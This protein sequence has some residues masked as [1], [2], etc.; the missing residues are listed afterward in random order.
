MNIQALIE[1]LNNIK[2][3]DL[4]A[5]DYKSILK[6]YTKRIDILIDFVLII[7]TL[8]FCVKY[9]Q[10]RENEIKSATNEIPM[11]KE[12]IAMI[13]AYN[14]ADLELQ[15]FIRG[16]PPPI[17]ENDLTNF[18]TDLA[19]KYNVQISNFTPATIF[20]QELF[21]EMNIS[22]S[23]SIDKYRDLWLFIH[24]LENSQYPIRINYLSCSP[25]GS[26]PQNPH[27]RGQDQNENDTNIRASIELSAINYK[28]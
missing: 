14:K 11:L 25:S 7:A 1:K 26:R 17:S 4:K 15:E 9:F 5:L 20:S 27:K 3:D 10:A 2:L 6:Q 16:I 13:E 28:K 21:D 8:I 18:I 24:A 19:T 12:K 23:F 22:L